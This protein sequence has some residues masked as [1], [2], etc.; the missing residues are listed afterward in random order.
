MGMDTNLQTL[1]DVLTTQEELRNHN[2]VMF[3]AATVGVV[4]KTPVYYAPFSLFLLTVLIIG[5]F[6]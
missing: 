4:Q 3:N 2:L 6:L 5:F 1:A